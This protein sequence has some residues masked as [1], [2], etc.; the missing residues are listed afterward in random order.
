MGQRSGPLGARRRENSS[1]RSSIRRWQRWLLG[2]HVRIYI[3]DDDGDLI[4]RW[5]EVR[6]VNFEGSVVVQLEVPFGVFTV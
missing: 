3:T 5:R 6:V 4:F 2:F 1:E